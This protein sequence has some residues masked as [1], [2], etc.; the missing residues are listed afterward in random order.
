MIVIVL[1]V[2]IVIAL[3][4]FFIPRK[5]DIDNIAIPMK[6]HKRKQQHLMMKRALNLV[7]EK[8]R[9]RYYEDIRNIYS[10][11]LN[12]CDKHRTIKYLRV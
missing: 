12:D 6:I 9:R 4:L 7:D 8:S 2:I 10:K 11:A 3:I 1:C 5:D